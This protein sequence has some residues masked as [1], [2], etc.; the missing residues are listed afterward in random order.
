MEELFIYGTVGL[1][2]LVVFLIYLRKL[3]NETKKSEHQIEKAHGKEKPADEA[4]ALCRTYAGEQVERQKKDF[5]RLGVLG[6]WDQPYLT[7]NFQTEADEIRALG[8]IHRKGFLFKGLKPVNWCFDC[9]SALAEAE[10][11]YQDKTSPTLDVGFN[12]ADE[13]R[14]KLATA[15]GLSEAPAGKIYA[16][17]WTTTPWTIPANQALNIHPELSYALVNTPKGHVILASD[18]Q[19]NVRFEGVS[20]ALTTPTAKLRL[21]GKPDTRPGRR[22]GVALTQGASTDEARSRAEASAHCVRIVP[23]A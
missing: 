10:V 3:R 8:E 16:V 20:D 19:D 11:E 18:S 12:I 5:V 21:F 7:M 17:I 4:R 2:C 23:Q 14:S 1:I 22:M 13:D 9:G 15:F 6:E